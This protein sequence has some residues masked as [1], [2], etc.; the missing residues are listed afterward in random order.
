MPKLEVIA[1]VAA[2]AVV[3]ALA[4]TLAPAEESCPAPVVGP[5]HNAEYGFAFV[6]PKGL[7][8]L[9]QSPCTLD[10][11]GKCVCLGNHGLRFVL[12]NDAVLGVFASYV[13]EPEDPTAEDVLLSEL[14]RIASKDFAP[15]VH[16]TSIENFLLK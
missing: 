3:L 7:K 1:R 16:I 4:A 13:P 8:G 11:S 9:W 2:S 14:N 10:T 5:Y 12:G 6:V 15:T